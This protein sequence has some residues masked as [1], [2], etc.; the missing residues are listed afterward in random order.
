MTKSK[1]PKKPRRKEK[2]NHQWFD[3]QV[4]ELLAAVERLP[5]DRR[6]QLLRELEGKRER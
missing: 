1:E 3:A 6:E 4:A 2:R 5:A